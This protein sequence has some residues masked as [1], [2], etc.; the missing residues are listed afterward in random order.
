MVDFDKSDKMIKIRGKVDK[1]KHLVVIFRSLFKEELLQTKRFSEFF[2][3][4][5]IEKID[6]IMVK[7]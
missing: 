7:M 6:K 2:Y 4:L 3:I 5:T 1:P